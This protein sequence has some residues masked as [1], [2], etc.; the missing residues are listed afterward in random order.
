[1]KSSKDTTVIV[2]HE[3]DLRIN[4]ENDCIKS[5][6]C[7]CPFEG[8]CK[9]LAGVLYYADNHPE[10]FKSDPDIYTVMDGMSSDELRE[11]LIPELINDY[12]LSNKFRLFTNQD[13]DEEYYI[14]KLKNSWDNSTEVFKFIDDDMQSLINAGRF[15]LIFKLCDVL[16]L[17]LDE[18]NYEHMWYA[19]EN[20]CEKLEKLMCQLISSE[21]RNQA[22]EFMAKVILDSED[23]ALSD[24]FSFIYSKY[25]DTDALFDE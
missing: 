6:Y 11:F 22:K 14:E 3:Y 16:I 23:E 24:G 5:M 2:Y 9:H 25:W 18:Y 21:C 8:N 19:Y 12:E 17:I 7:N 10:I 13:I 4:F 20:L 15:D 1:M